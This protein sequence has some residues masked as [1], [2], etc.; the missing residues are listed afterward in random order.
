M[1]RKE[2][3]KFSKENYT[4]WCG[5]M[6]LYLRTLG[7]HYQNHVITKYNEPLEVLTPDQIKERQDNTTAMDLIAS[8]L[9]DNEY[10]EVQD[11]KTIFQMWNKLKIVYGGDPH[12]QKAKVD[13]LRGKYDEMRMQEGENIEEYRKII[14]NV[15]NSIKS[16]GGKLEED[17]VVRKILRTL[18]P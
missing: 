3:P 4:L 9:S 10:V 5:R 11:L 17:D 8:S 18:L 1:M 12:I 15:V 6:R 14:K 16:V 13:S 7:E 2:G